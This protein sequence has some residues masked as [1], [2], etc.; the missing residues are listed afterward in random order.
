MRQAIYFEHPAQFCDFVRLHGA[1]ATRS[2]GKD[3]LFEIYRIVSPTTPGQTSV[4]L[5]NCRKKPLISVG[6]SVKAE[7]VPNLNHLKTSFTDSPQPVVEQRF[8]RSLLEAI[9]L[10]PVDPRNNIRLLDEAILFWIPG[11]HAAKLVPQLIQDSLQ[12]GN[13][14]IQYCEFKLSRKDTATLLRIDSPSFFLIQKCIEE[15][16]D[17][18]QVYYPASETLFVRWGF[19]HPLEDWWQEPDISK[20]PNWNFFPGD[21]DSFQIE[22]VTWRDAYDLTSLELAFDHDTI[23]ADSPLDPP[24]FTVPLRLLKKGNADSDPEVWL[25][26]EHGARY[27]ENTLQLTD[28]ESLRAWQIA[29]QTSKDHSQNWFFIRE[30]KTGQGKKHHDFGG[31]GFAKF[32]GINNLLLPVDYDLQ[33]PLRRDV[34]RHLFQ[35]EPDT[36]TILVP[37]ESEPDFFHVLK[38][39][40]KSFDGI[41]SFIDYIVESEANRLEDLITRSVFDFKEYLKVASHPGLVPDKDDDSDRKK[42]PANLPET[43]EVT[44]S[45]GS[46]ETKKSSSLLDRVEVAVEQIDESKLNELEKEEI[47]LEREIIDRGQSVELWHQLMLCKNEMGKTDEAL[48][49]AIEG[50]WMARGLPRETVLKESALNLAR[51]E[52]KGDFQDVTADALESTRRAAVFVAAFSKPETGPGEWIGETSSFLRVHEDGIR[53]KEKWLTRGS[54]LAVNQDLRMETRVREEIR[55][56]I[57]DHGLSLEETPVFIRSRIFLDRNLHSGADDEESGS[58]AEHALANLGGLLDKFRQTKS[59]TISRAASA[60]LARAYVQIGDIPRAQNLIRTS[61]TDSSAQA[62]ETLFHIEA[63][64]KIDQSR[65]ETLLDKLPSIL[66]NADPETQKAVS[67]LQKS[68]EERADAD[69]PAAFLARENRSRTYPGGGGT[70]KGT[71]YDLSMQLERHVTENAEPD[72][73][74]VMLKMMTIEDRKEYDDMVKLPQF[75][76]TLVAGIE[77]F[78]WGDR[79]SSVFPVFEEFSDR[80]PGYLSHKSNFFYGAILHSNLALGLLAIENLEKATS[81]IGQAAD[82]V[83]KN[84][85]ELDFIDSAASLIRTVE[86]LPLT[87]RPGILLQVQERFLSIF[88]SDQSQY[89]TNKKLFAV[90]VKL[91]DQLAEAASS[92]D[93]LSLNQFRSYQLQDEFLILQRIQQESFCQNT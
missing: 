17:E 5:L 60:I 3:S 43:A 48:L 79:G 80:A 90:L 55:N 58:G 47:A 81:Q 83:C 15:S 84:S 93:R 18:L 51:A 33:P 64:K 21:A 1:N 66:E 86:Q 72:A 32:K 49:C 78:K 50:L 87:H 88:D 56:Q 25:L 37:N 19:Q 67:E 39:K 69:N 29:L 76:E 36:L 70:E 73:V 53:A 2:K 52:L 30:I 24:H 41:A 16:S 85:N 61:Q 59:T 34:Y 8:V 35:L 42:K 26:D 91:I 75:V 46:T 7:F 40:E 89:V 13:D 68:Y 14:R 12:L 77:R 6:K 38:I 92:R 27:L 74:A 31:V 44:S 11:S 65:A 22:P 62:W 20:S 4:V 71:L 57:T 23:W 28:D 82:L 9:S 63:L 10:T 45:S 54:V